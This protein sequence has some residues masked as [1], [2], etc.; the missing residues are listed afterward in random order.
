MGNYNN[1][2]YLY[3]ARDTTLTIVIE[4]DNNQC[5][6]GNPN[7]YP[8]GDYW[9]ASAYSAAYGSYPV[10]VVFELRV[11]PLPP[12]IAPPTPEPTIGLTILGNPVQ[13]EV[14]RFTT[15]LDSERVLPMLTGMMGQSIPFTLEH[16]NPAAGLYQLRLHSALRPGPYGLRVGDE[17]K[18]LLAR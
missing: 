17:A 7:L 15:D 10:P 3:S 12:R 6:W 13:G 18:M 14:I 9:H 11:A 4:S 8:V 1:Q 5:S 16:V 2:L